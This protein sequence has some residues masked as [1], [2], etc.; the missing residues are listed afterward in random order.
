METENLSFWQRLS[1]VNLLFL[2]GT[3]VAAL[4]L[5]PLQLYWQGWSWSLFLFL[6]VTSAIT[7]LSITAGYHR[8][9]SHRSYD[10][11]PWLK[12]LYLILGA[13]AFQGSALQW[14]KDHRRHHRFVDT[15]QDP[16]NI[17]YGFLYA[18]VGWLFFKEQD[19]FK[20]NPFPHDLADDPWVSWQHRN[21]VPL[22]IGVGFVLPMGLGWLFFNNAFGGLVYGGV[23]RVV[24]CNHTTFLINS[25]AHT[26]GRKPYNQYQT[27]RDSVVMA[28]LAYGE[29]YH[30]YHHAFQADY[31]NGIRWYHWDPTKWLIRSL[32]F[33]GW[34]Y[35][36]KA[37]PATEILKARL[38]TDQQVLLTTG[39]SEER[40]N[41]LKQKVEEAQKRWKTL[42]EDYRVLKR[43]VQQS[44]RK[45]L[46][47][48]KAE[49]K[50]A[51]LEFKMALAQWGAFRRTLRP[52]TVRL[53][54]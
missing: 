13:G 15:E 8:Y 34:T 24:L 40:I 10:A 2:S 35:K 47:Q 18:H 1:W 19:I 54:R 46:V 30:N 36:L 42:C 41:A 3:L 51:R 20:Q 50:V 45:H 39:V 33:I 29:G 11:K 26:L 6:G 27:A 12:A 32:S 52:L 17:H 5:T 37:A 31:R 25:L 48:Y 16:H 22:A 44:S 23:L 4:I 43:S 38:R 9:L 7:N 28:I 49:L 21:F 14:C 53:A